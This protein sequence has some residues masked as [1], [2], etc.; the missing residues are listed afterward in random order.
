MTEEEVR[1]KLGLD[2]RELDSGTR[3]ALQNISGFGQE[4]HKSFLHG[5]NAAKGFKKTI[6]ELSDQVPLLGNALRLA[7]SPV[8]GMFA[9]A[10]SGIAAATA[11]LDK[12]NE[13][14]DATGKFNAQGTGARA[15][16]GIAR[17]IKGEAAA[18]ASA[19][20]TAAGKPTFSPEQTLRRDQALGHAGDT[21][22]LIEENVKFNKEHPGEEMT[23]IE[24]AGALGWK[25]SLRAMFGLTPKGKDLAGVKELVT[26]P[27]V[28]HQE[29]LRSRVEDA[30]LMLQ[31]AQPPGSGIGLKA[32][33]FLISNMLG[34]KNL[35]FTARA[36]VQM[37]R[38]MDIRAAAP[39]PGAELDAAGGIAY[40]PLPGAP[41]YVPPI[42]PTATTNPQQTHAQTLIGVLQGWAANG[43]P[44]IGKD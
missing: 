18:K 32:S 2:T 33:D 43:V 4:A 17:L 8:G 15:E 36:A 26:S 3:R 34:L 21:A 1:I 28:H 40:H 27:D 14:L 29:A 11:A 25:N 10:A 23:P 24:T 35:G 44:V 19:D 31:H 38:I 37:K 13:K 6:H 12:F 9:L 22:K 30:Q 16:T 5:D 7:I 39:V 41:G 20:A 42:V